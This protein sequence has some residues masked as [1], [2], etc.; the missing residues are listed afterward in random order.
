MYILCKYCVYMFDWSYQ[1]MFNRLIKPIIQ[2]PLLKKKHKKV[3][4]F[5]LQQKKVE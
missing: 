2:K 3:N 1:S 4:N 5:Q